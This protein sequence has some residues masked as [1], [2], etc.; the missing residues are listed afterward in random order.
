MQQ[1]M[2]NQGSEADYELTTNYDLDEIRTRQTNAIYPLQG[3]NYFKHAMKKEENML[4]LTA[5]A[6]SMP[7]TMGME[8]RT[9]R[10]HLS[11]CETNFLNQ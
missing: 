6:L 7:L 3:H 9:Q 2:V 10:I 8:V 1:R 11:K 5:T 4:I